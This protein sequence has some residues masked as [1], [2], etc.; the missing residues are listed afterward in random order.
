MS[1]GG[2]FQCPN[3]GEQRVWLERLAGQRV[4]CSCGAMVVVPAEPGGVVAIAGVAK[5]PPAG[6]GGAIP[7]ASAKAGDEKPASPY[8]H[9]LWPAVFA[10]AGLV[11]MIVYY[12]VAMPLSFPMAMLAMCIRLAID[13]VMLFAGCLLAMKLLDM[14]LG[15][16]VEAIIKLLGVALLPAAVESLIGQ[17]VPG[18][19]LLGWSISIGLYGALLMWFFGL[20]GKEVLTLTTIVWLV[21][22]WGA[23]VI[24]AMLMP[25]VLGA[26]LPLN[27]PLAWALG[28][29]ETDSKAPA[30]TDDGKAERL[31]ENGA[32]EANL[33]TM[34]PQ[35]KLSGRDQQTSNRYVNLLYKAG[36][37]TVHVAD[38]QKS[39]DGFDVAAT[40]IVK[41]PEEPAARQKV[42]ETAV[43]PVSGGATATQSPP[44]D[45]EYLLVHMPPTPVP[46]PG[47]PGEG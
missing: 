28:N 11:L 5:V 18:G 27:G 31:L 19:F 16:P 14:S 12:A 40:L 37:E 42:V 10:A 20:N 26:H 6:R 22:S 36:A 43:S 1:E 13:F 30:D 15:E 46:S 24:S 33:W 34:A 39:P 9:L 21:Q 45:Q 44:A 23:L 38:V 4:R 47:N 35:H 2:L 3:C 32:I 8:A 41:L 25:N 7:Y 29:G 17:F